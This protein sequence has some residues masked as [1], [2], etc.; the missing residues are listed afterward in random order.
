MFGKLD[1]AA[2]I[3]NKRIKWTGHVWRR[4]ILVINWVQVNLYT[5]INIIE[6]KKK[7]SN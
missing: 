3:K 4:Y 6:V 5:L 2:K 7:K 1:I